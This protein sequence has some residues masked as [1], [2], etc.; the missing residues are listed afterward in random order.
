MRLGHNALGTEKKSKKGILSQHYFLQG[1]LAANV[2]LKRALRLG[3]INRDV[4]V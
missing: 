4:V 1:H 3:F 2:E